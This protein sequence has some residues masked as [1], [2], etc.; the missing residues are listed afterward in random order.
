VGE[1]EFQRRI[2]GQQLLFLLHDQVVGTLGVLAVAR[3]V[4]TGVRPAAF[5]VDGEVAVVDF[6]GGTRQVDFAEQTLISGQLGRA[7]IFLFEDARVVA[8]DRVAVGVVLAVLVH[9]ID[10]E[11]R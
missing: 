11:Q 9:R 6:L 7:A 1:D 10:E 2:E 3:G 8:L 4:F 5:L